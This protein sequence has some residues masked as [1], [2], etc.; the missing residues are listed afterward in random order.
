MRNLL[1]PGRH[2]LLTNFQLEY[3]TRVTSGDRDLLRDAQGNPIELTEPIQ[4]LLWAVTSANH[5]NTRRNPLPAHRREVA[6]EEFATQLDVDSYV[7][8]IDDLGFT[9]RFAEYVL[10]KIGVDSLG[11]FSLTPENTLVASSTPEVISQYERLGYRVLPVELLDRERVTFAADPPWEVMNKIVADGL[12]GEDWKK[13]SH[14]IGKVS[15]ATRRLYKKYGYGDQIIELHRSPLLTEDGDLTATRDYNTYVRSFD[16]GATRKLSLVREFVQPGRIVD[17]G[18]C[19]GALLRELTF[20][21]RLRE[22]DFFGIEVAR[23]LYA[24]CLHRKEQGLF[25]AENVF[26]YQKDFA[27]CQLFA[28]NSI[29]TFTTFALTHEIESY[30]GRDALESFIHNLYE[31]LNIG[32]RWINVDVV[33]P[34]D[35][36]KRVLMKLNKDDG[37]EVDG[38]KHHDIDRSFDPDDRE[39]LKSFLDGLSTYDRFLRFARDFRM[40]EGFHLPYELVQRGAE[41]YVELSLQNACEFLSKKDYT[42]NWSSEMHE[43]FCFWDFPDWL[44]AV[45]RAGFRVLDAS[46]DYRNPW[47][48]ENRY[49][50]K[51]E[52]YDEGL[53]PLEYPVT[54]M[55]LVAVKAP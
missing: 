30:S 18:C 14:F 46:T 12:R 15:R 10:K 52:L 27:S 51:V 29:N 13:N 19:T 7:F 4:T 37:T 53:Q 5:S 21:P 48:I 34:R 54:N 11:R 32:G 25:N 45:Q 38:G 50:N 1:F 9:E 55:I 44:S 3:L 20:E 42:D 40:D 47:I 8:L 43:T 24:E 39:G 33:G 2:H 31:Q 28:S 49:R 17:I 23:P 22:S 26:F 41:Q 16:S 36:T 35:K 6:I